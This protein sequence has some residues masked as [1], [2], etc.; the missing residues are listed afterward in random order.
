MLLN[1]LKYLVFVFDKELEKQVWKNISWKI[2][3]LSK[4]FLPSILP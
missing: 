3:F 1:E 4:E 2:K